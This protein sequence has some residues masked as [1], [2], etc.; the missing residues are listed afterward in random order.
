[1][2]KPFSI[3]PI[4]ILVL[5]VAVLTQAQTDPFLGTWKL[6]V[7]K[8]KFVPGP[9]RKSETRMVVTGPNGMNVSVKRVNGDGNT[10]EFEYTTNLDGKSY[11]ITGDGPEGADSIAVNLTA[12]K[13]MQ[14]TLTK[15]GKV[16]GTA[17]ISVSSDGKVLTITSKGTSADGKQFSVIAV[18]DKQ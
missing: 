14:A 5:F 12:P 4:V 9:P 10:Q 7:K 15:T 6:N 11:P 17:T 18:Y 8:S 1:M 16:V 2:K 13:T 3:I